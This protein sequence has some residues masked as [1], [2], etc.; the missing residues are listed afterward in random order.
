[1]SRRHVIKKQLFAAEPMATT[2]TSVE[3][4]VSELDKAS[5]HASWVAGPVGE[6][7]VEVKQYDEGPLSDTWSVL[8]TGAPWTISA[9]DSE[10]QIMLTHMSFVKLRLVYEPTSGTGSLTAFLTASTVGA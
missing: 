7:R 6:F 9:L 1:M 10:V 3:L 4:T 5:I 2:A 8:E